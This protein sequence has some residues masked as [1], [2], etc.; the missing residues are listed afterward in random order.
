VLKKWAMLILFVVAASPLP[1]EPVVIPLGLIRY[2][3]AKLF[4][5]Y[6]AGKLVIGIAGAYLGRFYHEIFFSTVN[7][8]LLMIISIVV[9]IVITIV[10]L[11]IDFEKL[12]E[13]ILKRK[14]QLIPR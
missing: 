7:D 4:L 1:D 9:T 2:N 13:K 10:L 11:R 5:A 12:A 6:F 14:I 8:Q 3:P